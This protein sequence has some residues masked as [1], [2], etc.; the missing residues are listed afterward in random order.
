[1]LRNVICKNERLLLRKVM[2][3]QLTGFVRGTICVGPADSEF[4]QMA[5]GGRF[6]LVQICS[7]A[8]NVIKDQSDWL[9]GRNHL[10]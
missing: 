5:Q 7:V 10:C 8:Y 3:R 9:C 2:Y 1:M 6:G 4:L